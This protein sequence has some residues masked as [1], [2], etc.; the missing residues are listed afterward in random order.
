MNFN[1]TLPFFLLF[2]FSAFQTKAQDSSFQLKD[3]KFRTPGFRALKV[4]LNL[5]GSVYDAKYVNQHNFQSRSFNTNPNIDYFRITSTDKR[6]HTSGMSLRPSYYSNS[7][8]FDTSK[9]KSRASTVS[10]N[11]N[12][13]DRFFFKKNFFFETGNEFSVTENNSRQSYNNSAYNTEGRSFNNKLTLGVGKGRLE[14]VQDAQ[15][16]MFIVNDLQKM[17][18][19][20]QDISAY[21][22]NEL[23]I[24]IT[25]I[26]NRRVFDNR[27]RRIYELSRI[28]SFFK[29]NNFVNQPSIAYFT[30]VNDNWALAFNPGRLSGTAFYFRFRPSVQWSR[31]ESEQ[32]IPGNNSKSSN[33][34]F[35]YSYEPVIGFE[36]QKPVN[37]YWQKSMGSSLSFEQLWRRSK[38]AQQNNNNPT[39]P[40]IFENSSGSSL[41]FN[42]FYGVGY[43][44]N[45]RTIINGGFNLNS[46]YVFNNEVGQR[47]DFYFEP[48][49]FLNANYFVNFR[50]RFFLNATTL[51]RFFEPGSV[52]TPSFVYQR[53]DFNANI[54]LGFS[55]VIL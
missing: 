8:R 34:I 30:T 5:N 23:A 38:S 1:Y 4:D 29:V 35:L 43:Y 33:R 37:L 7:S 36:K 25:D 50:T 53:A 39:Q 27:I 14:N 31:S 19:L 46:R 45:N 48:G 18:L 17:G 15:M 10:F 40:A 26:N 2:I 52:P 22:L 42:A 12:R 44:P 3:Y 54:S 32:N 28:D 41:L 24:L 13:M 20:Q 55:H 11:H 16:A 9:A 47:E 6:Q 49:V 21:K 51:Y